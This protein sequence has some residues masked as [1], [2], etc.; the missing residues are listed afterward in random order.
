MQNQD[1]RK[2]FREEFVEER[3]V[4]DILPESGVN[5]PEAIIM[6]IGVFAKRGKA[7]FLDRMRRN[8]CGMFIIIEQV[9]SI[10]K[11]GNHGGRGKKIKAVSER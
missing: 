5:S 11:V 7:P 10:K 3:N 2:L 9:E 8:E 1:I 6:I 4:E